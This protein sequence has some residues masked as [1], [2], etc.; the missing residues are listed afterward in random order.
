MLSATRMCLFLFYNVLC[1]AVKYNRIFFYFSDTHSG[2]GGYFQLVLYDVNIL[3][4]IESTYNA[5]VNGITQSIINAHNNMFTG[6]IFLSQTEVA[7]VGVNRSPYAY[8]ENP[9]TERNRYTA[10]IDRTM[11]Q[12]RFVDNQNRLRGA[13]H[14][15]AIHA[16]SMNNT[17][18]LISSDNFG[19]S[20]MM[21]EAEYNPGQLVGRG[22]FIG[23][24][25]T[26]HSGDVSP[27]IVGPN[28]MVSL[29]SF[30]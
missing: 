20:S 7:S 11:H 18:R 22:D 21:L 26:A 13:F 12:L 17:N 24:F 19:V 1:T 3:G 28:C 29:S 27:N 9:Q 23:A 2:P 6:R 5:C 4:F 15:L 30:F 25:S 8:D 16:V 10:N 14:W